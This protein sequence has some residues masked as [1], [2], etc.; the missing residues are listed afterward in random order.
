MQ[1]PRHMSVPI[2]TAPGTV[3]AVVYAADTAAAVANAAGLGVA[4][5][6][7][8]DGANLTRRVMVPRNASPAPESW[9]IQFGDHPNTIGFYGPFGANNIGIA[10]GIGVGLIRF[11]ITGLVAT[12]GRF[13]LGQSLGSEDVFIE[14]GGPN[15]VQFRNN[16]F[17]Q[18]AEFHKT[19]TSNDVREFIRIN[20]AATNGAT[21]VYRIE[22]GKGT[23]GGV[24]RPIE[25]GG[26][27]GTNFVPWL[28]L[29]TDQSRFGDVVITP[30]TNNSR[31]AVTAFGTERTRMDLYGYLAQRYSDANSGLVFYDSLGGASNGAVIRSPNA[32]TI[33]INQPDNSPIDLECRSIRM[34]LPSSVSLSS[35]N[36][37]TVERVSNTEINLVYRGD[38]GITRRS[39]MTLT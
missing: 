3:G 23:T 7:T 29:S 27:D 32:S 6:P 28:T 26:N 31:L 15:V 1:I 5:S 10:S 35:D 18:M 30:T 22:S 2:P 38:D 37:L 14:R 9:A 36:L 17:G 25:I 16:A 21:P 20:A 39:L 19:W 24:V 13:A 34:Q 8:W 4:N 33:R 12:I 11:D